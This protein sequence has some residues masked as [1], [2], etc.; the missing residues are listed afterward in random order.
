MNTASVFPTRNFKDGQFEG[1]DRISGQTMKETILA[2]Q[3]G[4]YACPIRCKRVVE[5]KNDRYQ[6]DGAYGGPEYETIAAFGSDC[7]VDDLEGIAKANEI[8]NAY[9]ADT[10]STGGMI[11]FSMECFEEGLLS[12]RD[13]EGLELRFG[14]TEAMVELTLQICQRRGFGNILAEGPDYAISKIGPLS[15][16]FS[17]DVKNQNLP[18]HECRARHG[19]GLGYA[20]SPTGAD[21]I[22]NFW[23]NV[24][25]NDPPSEEAQEL[26]LYE[27]MPQ[28]VL[29]PQK[30]RA[31]M[32]GTN[33]AW[34]HNHL[35]SCIYVPWSRDQIVAL[36]RAI[37]GWQTNVWELLKV[38]E[39]GVTLSRVFNMREGFTR[40]DDVLPERMTTPVRKYPG[41]APEVFE[42]SLSTFYGMMGWNPETGLPTLDKLRELDVEWAAQHLS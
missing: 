18:M 21:H 32:Y 41:I 14:N 27:C 5:V 33:W 9:G 36:V 6:V 1:A 28:T 2:D 13:T 17:M 29:N 42:E 22:H 10:I 19:L 23:D 25:A 30:V 24:V 35:G 37:T 11:A 8:C 40:S 39:R 12:T 7:G 3:G 16:R 20:V 34:I 15:R 4:C 31:Y 38:A 26:G